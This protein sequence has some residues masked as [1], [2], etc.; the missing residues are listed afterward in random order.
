M[1]LGVALSDL[2]YQLRAETY[3]SLLPAHGVSSNDMFNAIL[4]RTQ[5]AL[6]TKYVWPHLKYHSDQSINAG[7]RYLDFPPDMPFDNIVDVWYSQPTQWFIMGYGFDNAIYNINGN[8]SFQS[9]PPQMWRN[10]VSWDPATGLTDFDGSM[11]IWPIPNQ[12]TVLRLEGQ[13][14]LNPLLVDTDRCMIDDTAIILT[15]AGELLGAQKSEMAQAK[16]AEAQAYVRRL[17][18]K[19]ANKRRISI[20]GGGANLIQQPTPYL[21]FVPQQHQ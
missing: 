8:E 6:W 21:D 11:E 12:S 2:R 17:L 4:Q 13:A 5:K 19:G 10:V 15:A 9:W 14:P 7:T 18:G 20:L 3:N 16:T 1:S